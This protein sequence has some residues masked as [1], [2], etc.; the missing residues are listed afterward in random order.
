MREREQ[1]F[2]PP[3]HQG[4]VTISGQI[5]RLFHRQAR[6]KGEK[7]IFWYAGWGDVFIATACDSRKEC[8]ETARTYLKRTV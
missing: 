6:L 3:E 7:K 5:V 4:T 8:I 1:L 2:S